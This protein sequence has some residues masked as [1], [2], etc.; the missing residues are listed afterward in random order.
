MRN[1]S[2][3]FYGWKIVAATFGIMTIQ[4]GT[5]FYTYG[6]LMKPLMQE[7]G[8]SRM[9]TSAAQTICSICSAVSA[10]IIGRLIQRID[11]KKILIFGAVLGATSLVLLS[12]INNIIQLYF[13]Y[14][15]IGI[16]LGGA[17][18]TLVTGVLISNWFN[19]KMGLAMG[20]STVG[21][22]MGAVVIVPL[23]RLVMDS[24]GWRGA[25]LFMSA[26][27]L[28]VDIPLAL[29]VLK[30]SP[31]KMNLHPD[32]REPSA[33]ESLPVNKVI[34]TK[35]SDNLPQN[36]L[37]SILKHPVLWL[38]CLGM[39]TCL[40]GEMSIMNHEA[41]F[42][43]D[44]GIPA[45]QAAAAISFTGGMGAIGKI[46]FGKL[47]D[48]LS[49]RYVIIACFMLQLVGV[50]ILKQADTMA[51]VWLFVIVFGF[52]MGGFVTLQPLA[53]RSL[54]GN[55]G[56]AIVLGFVGFFTNIL[57]T[58]GPPF[59]GFIYD[60]TGSYATAFNIFTVTYI[61]AIVLIYFAW[62]RG[63]K[64]FKNTSVFLT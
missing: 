30:I 10:L 62:G 35:E 22:S 41:A 45:A 12:R 48:K 17:T 15:L 21:I 29:F 13:L 44:M 64:P 25:Y 40:L 43:T 3:I 32:G 39:G 4:A 27:V 24:F 46:T 58:I 16:G 36:S 49:A 42:I 47:C 18:G 50:F 19:R 55:A 61:V 26:A 9:S 33:L 2:R 51:M 52:S 60:T 38:L 20:I 28:V 56:F 59:A 7:F 23:V 37:S 1:N 8:W 31:A 5:T 54:F 11:I 34:T 53:V 63:P 6:I 14:S 57:G